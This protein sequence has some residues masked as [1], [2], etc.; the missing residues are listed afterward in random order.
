MAKK[1]D[2]FA[3]IESGVFTLNQPG[4]YTF[5]F[6]GS[7]VS[8]SRGGT[9]VFSDA[10]FSTITAVDLA[11]ANKINIVG[12][13]FVGA[14]AATNHKFEP[15]SNLDGFLKAV[16]DTY[17]VAGAVNM[18]SVDGAKAGVFMLLWDYI[19]DNYSY[20][21]TVINGYG[22]ELGIA[23]AKYLQ[24]GGAPLTDVVAKFTPDGPDAG[25]NPDRLQSMH[26]NLLGNLHIDSI[27]DKFFDGNAANGSPNAPGY[28]SGGSNATPD[29]AKGQALLDTLFGLDLDG[30]P[31][32]G[33][34]EGSDSGPS[35][36]WDVDHGLL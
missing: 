2:K 5:D 13:K 12:I 3:S 9:T 29:E 26:D 18:L 36:T 28:A 8:V 14:D 23:Y 7:S 4:N 22:V 32:Y 17:G 33:G 10:Q 20:Y 25:S 35:H 21:N 27:I 19:D 6:T 34:N 24:A 1:T 30:R 11:A 16:L 15:D 31:Y